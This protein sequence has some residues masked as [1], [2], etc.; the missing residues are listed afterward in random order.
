M[1]AAISLRAGDKTRSAVIFVGFLRLGGKWLH[2]PCE[3]E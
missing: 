2:S 1:P 3:K